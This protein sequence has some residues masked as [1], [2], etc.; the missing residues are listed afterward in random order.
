ML[1]T[2][3]GIHKDYTG[4]I[5]VNSTA[6][7]AYMP[8]RSCLTPHFPLS[9]SDVV[10]MG[11]WRELGA[12][13]RKKEIHKKRVEEALE[14]VGMAHYAHRPLFQLSG[15]QTQRVLFAR[16]MVQNG[17]FL[18]LDEPFEGIDRPTTELLMNLILHWNAQGKTV[19]TVLH[20][21]DLVEANFDNALFVS[22]E[23]CFFGSSTE[24]LKAYRGHRLHG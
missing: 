13:R 20:S 11:L 17:D 4:R 14:A 24:V 19:L 5:D 2:L 18:I 7:V 9:V 12:W 6:C 22:G 8:Q 15:G 10:S 3:V 16:L 21:V 1:R 23:R